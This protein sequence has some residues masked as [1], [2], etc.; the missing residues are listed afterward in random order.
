[1][2]GHDEVRQGGSHDRVAL[3]RFGHRSSLWI[4]RRIVWRARD[5]REATVP[6]AGDGT[7][8]IGTDA[9]SWKVTS[10]T[11]HEPLERF[12]DRCGAEPAGG[13]SACLTPA[14][15]ESAFP[16]IATCDLPRALRFYRDLLD[17]TV[18]YQFPPEGE[19]V[20]AGIDIGSS[21]LGIGHD[22]TA[23]EAVPQRFSLWVYAHDCDAAVDRLRAAGVV[24]VEEPTDQP[25]GERV[26]RVLDPDG[27]TVIIGSPS[28]ADA[29]SAA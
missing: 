3:D 5:S 8:R 10:L 20:Y 1:V 6:G 26:A 24:V 19:P 18:A 13:R 2:F 23:R 17:G 9:G 4:T 16:I 25:W 15:F 7:R 21:H 27:K 29:G 28:G 12:P 14:M 22:A 11:T